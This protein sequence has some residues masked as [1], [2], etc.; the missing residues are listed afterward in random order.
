MLI[1]KVEY[2]GQSAGLSSG[3]YRCE[4][5]LQPDQWVDLKGVY[6]VVER[7]VP[8]KPGDPYDG[9]LICKPAIG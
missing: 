5:R 3:T 2:R 6:L 8:A 1:Y 9:I 7:I 4:D